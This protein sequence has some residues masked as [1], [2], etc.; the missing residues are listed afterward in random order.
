MGTQKQ[1]AMAKLLHSKPTHSFTNSHSQ[2]AICIL[3]FFNFFIV[4]QTDATFE[5]KKV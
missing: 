3:F 4:W 5:P 1:K 2:A